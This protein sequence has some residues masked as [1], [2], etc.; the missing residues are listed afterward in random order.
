M[1]QKCPRNFGF[2]HGNFSLLKAISIC[3]RQFQFAHGNFSL[4]TAISIYSRQFRNFTQGNFNFFY[5]KAHGIFRFS[6]LSATAADSGHAPKVKT[7]NQKSIYELAEL[8]GIYMRLRQTQTSMSSY[9]SPYIPF[10]AFTDLKMN[11]DRSNFI[12]VT[13]PTRVTFVPVW[14]RTVLIKKTKKRTSDRVHK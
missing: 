12:S 8:G 14:D 6:H 4:P 2:T 5:G 10:H 11:S 1:A 3:S 13:D 7:Q 9:R